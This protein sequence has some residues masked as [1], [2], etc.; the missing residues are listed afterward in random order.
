MNCECSENLRLQE[1]LIRRNIELT[2]AQA[3]NNNYNR[4]SV[5]RVKGPDIKKMPIQP[6]RFEEEDVD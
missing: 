1:E 4:P 2:Q 5:S 3:S 6:T